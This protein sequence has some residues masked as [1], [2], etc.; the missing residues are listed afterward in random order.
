MRHPTNYDGKTSAEDCNAYKDHAKNK[1]EDR[2]LKEDHEDV[3]QERPSSHASEHQLKTKEKCGETLSEIDP[4]GKRATHKRHLAEVQ[5]PPNVI[6]YV[7][8][9]PDEPFMQGNG[10][11][12]RRCWLMMVG[13]IGRQRLPGPS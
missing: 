12:L 7:V 3:G 2:A 4:K 11:C 10:H 13:R 5:W 8:V 1:P 6:G 9:P